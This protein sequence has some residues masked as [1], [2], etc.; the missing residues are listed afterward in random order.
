MVIS[1][2]NI[3]I[4]YRPKPKVNVQLGW[5]SLFLKSSSIKTTASGLSYEIGVNG[6][7]KSQSKLRLLI[8]TDIAHFTLVNLE[9][10]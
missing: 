6:G 10:F 3:F 7:E 2:E 5:I 4:I 9:K 1:K 8:K